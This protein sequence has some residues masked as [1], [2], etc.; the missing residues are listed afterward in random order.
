M[1]SS[2]EDHK[3]EEASLIEFLRIRLNASITGPVDYT[4]DGANV[5]DDERELF[6]ACMGGE[7]PNMIECSNIGIGACLRG[8]YHYECIGITP[9]TVPTT[10]GKSNSSRPSPIILLILPLEVWFCDRCITLKKGKLANRIYF[11]NIIPRMSQCQTIKTYPTF[12]PSERVLTASSGIPSRTSLRG[13][14]RGNGVRQPMASAVNAESEDLSNSLKASPPMPKRF[15]RQAKN[16]ATKR[17]KSWAKGTVLC[18]QSNSSNS[19]PSDESG[20]GESK[21]EMKQDA[22]PLR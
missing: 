17:K 10:N 15:K 6:C 5:D 1:D 3:M 22:L 12:K 19:I 16:A 7:G 18:G 13:S 8:W 21:G 20:M 11:K 2:L 9:N 4:Q 14:C